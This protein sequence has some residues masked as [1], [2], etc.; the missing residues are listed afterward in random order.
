[1]TGTVT[2]SDALVFFGVTGDLAYKQIFPAL[3][4]MIKHGHLDIPVIGVAG[5]P[6]SID[7]LRAHV[8]DSLEEHGG[9]DP[10][11][12]EKLSSLLQYVSGDYHDETTYTTL[13]NAL[14]GAIHPL[15]YLAIPPSMFGPVV[16]GLGK[17]GSA[18]GAR[19]ILEKPF[20]RDLA[21]ARELN[22]ILHSVFPESSIFRIDH[23]LGKEPVQNVLY[24]RF[25]NSFLEPVW[26]RTYVESVQITMAENFGVAGRGKFYEEAGAIR[27][28]V[29]NHMLQLVALLAMVP[30]AGNYHESIRDEKARIFKAM[31]PIDPSNVV[32]GQYIGYH[33]ED[34]V[35]PRSQVETFA[36]LKLYLDTWRW[37]DVPFYIR[38]GKCMA[39][40]ATEILVEFKT[41][42]LAVFGEIEPPQSNYYRFR[43]S[44]DM[45]IS[46]GARTK[47]PGEAMWGEGVELVVRS[48]HTDEMPPYERL[49]RDAM[50]GDTTLFVREDS[51]EAAWEVVEPIL[52]KVSPVYRYAPNNWGPPEADRIIERDGGWHNPV[53]TEP[54]SGFISHTHG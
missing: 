48:H 54:V 16:E 34:G 46:L 20:G 22:Q 5:R 37:A 6:W 11:A 31:R 25:A 28:V 38:A 39:E 21:S 8:H 33:H 32:L 26:N 24:F 19:V 51:V 44:P 1:M 47:V 27:D 35:A 12:F 49:L 43:L 36:A 30:P 3:Q 15:Y 42:P 7:Q 41:P 29:Q 50:K 10:A 53:L 9:V 14:D 40:T 52:G 17:S 45:L 18:D 13:R 23:Y 2:Y 4:S